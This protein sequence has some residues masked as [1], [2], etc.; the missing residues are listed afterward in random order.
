MPVGAVASTALNDAALTP[1][2]IRRVS[3]RL[4]MSNA[5]PVAAQMVNVMPVR[6]G[7][8]QQPMCYPMGQF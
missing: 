1:R 8:D 3:H 2:Y 4:Q 7:S 6:Y 5:G